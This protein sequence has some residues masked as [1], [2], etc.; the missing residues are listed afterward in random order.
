MTFYSLYSATLGN[1]A[2]E[3]PS[4]DPTCVT[5]GASFVTSNKIEF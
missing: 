4:Y 5:Q 1:S 3:E 2:S